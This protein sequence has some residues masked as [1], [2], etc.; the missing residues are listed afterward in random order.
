MADILGIG[1]S[2]GPIILTPPEVWNKGR[3][4]IFARVSNY[5]P[6]R[7]CSANSAAITA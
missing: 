4:R 1:C 5:E 3:E 6:P 2:H 7:N